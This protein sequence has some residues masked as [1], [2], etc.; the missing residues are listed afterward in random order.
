MLRLLLSLYFVTVVGLISINWAS[1]F[2]WQ[3]ITPKENELSRETRSLIT[4][5]R[6]LIESKNQ[7]EID[8]INEQLDFNI[9][10]KSKKHYALLD[11]QYRLLKNDIPVVLYNDDSR[12]ILTLATNQQHFV[13]ITGL[14]EKAANNEIY[15]Y[16]LLGSSY[17]VLGLFLTIWIQPVWRDLKYLEF[18]SEKVKNNDFELP[19][20]R[21]HRSPISK[22]IQTTH[23]MTNRITALLSEQK[24]LI[25]AVSHELRTPLSRLHFSVAMQDSLDEREKQ[26]ISQD[27]TEIE[28]LVDE[29]LAYARLENLSHSFKRE[30]VNVPELLSAQ[31][32]KLRRN[33]NKQLTF[34][35][36][37][38][39]NFFC[40]PDLLERA[41]QNL[42]TNAL[43][44]AT[45]EI[46]VIVEIETNQLTLAVEDDGI[47]IEE[48][49]YQLVFKPF[50]RIDKSRNKHVTGYGLGLAIVKKAVDWHHG[51][52]SVS[53]SELGG[54]KFVIT[55]E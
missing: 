15:R 46:N 3:S 38:Q 10:L 11:E 34:K 27:V 13:V 16:L 33:S 4:P 2:I 22:I 25:N 43:K 45:K 36:N 1:E 39:S 32:D 8:E 12:E 23:D 44:Y 21:K 20:Y 17:I 51:N 5:L 18:V 49:N 29:M 53:R 30:N 41:S 24:Q 48:E 40:Q 42:I 37:G 35:Y 19:S 50:S 54:A 6:L 26:E 31:V 28:G 14:Q 55:L 47:G 52:Y 9:E 7:Q